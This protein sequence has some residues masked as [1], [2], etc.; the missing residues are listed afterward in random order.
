MLTSELLLPH[1]GETTMLL[2]PVTAGK[3]GISDLAEITVNGDT[4]KVKVV[5]DETVPASVALLPRSMGFSVR[6]PAVI[7]AKAAKQEGHQ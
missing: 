1:I 7:S 5:L 3:L 2:N 6:E 4:L